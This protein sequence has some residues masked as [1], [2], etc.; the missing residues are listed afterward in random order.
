V[1]ILEVV[2]ETD[3][4]LLDYEVLLEQQPSEA[5]QEA[6][7]RERETK[8]EASS[9][10]ADAEEEVRRCIFFKCCR[11]LSAVV[12]YKPMSARSFNIHF[13]RIQI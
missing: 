12:S 3:A 10:V 9:R 13:G 4:P 8:Q 7:Q 5:S 6:R 1:Q 2:A 11:A